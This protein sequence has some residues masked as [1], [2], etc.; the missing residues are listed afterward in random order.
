MGF[1]RAGKNGVSKGENL[2]PASR[3]DFAPR[4]PLFAYFG[5]I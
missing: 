4:L 1:R 3:C 2:L 5:I